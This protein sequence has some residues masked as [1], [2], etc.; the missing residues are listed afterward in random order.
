VEQESNA[1]DAAPVLVNLLSHGDGS[2]VESAAL[3]LVRALESFER[4]AGK[5]LALLP[6]THPYTYPSIM[7][8]RGAAQVCRTHVSAGV[9]STGGVSSQEVP[10]ATCTL[11][12]GPLFNAVVCLLLLLL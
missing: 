10:R 1:L 2:I 4:T 7:R 11:F 3:A 8:P 5:Q 6:C 9:T 12:D